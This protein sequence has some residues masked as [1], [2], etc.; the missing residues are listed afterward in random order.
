MEMT[1]TFQ[2]SKSKFT[3]G[4]QCHKRLWLQVHRPDL[5]K[6]DDFQ[7]GIMEQGTA[8][9]VL[10]RKAF[11]G[12]ELVPHG[13]SETELSATRT[14]IADPSVS[15]IFEATFAAHG[16]LA[17]IDVLQRVAP[18]VWRAV[19][20]K[21]AA[22]FEKHR[23]AFIDDAA[24]QDHVLRASGLNVASVGLMN[25]NSAYVYD[26]SVIEPAQFFETHDVTEDVRRRQESFQSEIAR[27]LEV[28]NQS[29]EPVC[30]MG[31]HCNKPHKCEFTHYCKGEDRSSLHVTARPSKE[32]HEWLSKLKWPLHFLDFET[33][34]P[35][36]PTYAGMHPWDHLPFQW[37]VHR[38]TEPGASLEHFEFLATGDCDPRPQF[39][40]TL[41]EA[42]G[43]A[44]SVIHYDHFENDRLNELLH[45]LPD[46][47]ASI[48][49]IQARLWD[50]AKAVRYIPEFKKLY[51]IKRVLPALVP[52]TDYSDLV[53][54]DG[55]AAMLAFERMAE[56]R[57]DLR[58]YCARDTRA[59]AQILDVLLGREKPSRV[60]DLIEALKQSLVASKTHGL[61]E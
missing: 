19:E 11:P 1:P 24:I 39:V 15:T 37:S 59:E 58:A 56:L 9:G 45:Q 28:L 60:P 29:S 41:C 44:G 22:N 21:S 8:V 53:I 12:G 34:N 33:G 49:R 47:A 51:S 26:G 14:L 55:T 43:D 5:A 48:Q 36:I 17:R 50:L 18:D 52:G 32:L 42:L 16:V 61:V 6:L 10:A 13:A 57:S 38:E 25:A 30:S 7:R 23:Q 3:A 27:Q 4:L 40:D 2:L 35:S 54:K 20:V 46:R 31:P